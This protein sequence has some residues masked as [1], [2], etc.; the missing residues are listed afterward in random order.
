[1]RNKTPKWDHKKNV[2][3]TSDQLGDQ[4]AELDRLAAKKAGET[5]LEQAA[6]L[7]V[8]EDAETPAALNDILAALGKLTFVECRAL[9]LA[10]LSVYD[11]DAWQRVVTSRQAEL[12]NNIRQYQAEHEQVKGE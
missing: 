10:L 11:F 8:A 9:I 12:C 1:M 4:L 2:Y 7:S 6:R 3:L 5:R